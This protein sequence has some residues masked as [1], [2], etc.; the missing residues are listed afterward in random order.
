[1]Y[2]ITYLLDGKPVK[3]EKEKYLQ[4]AWAKANRWENQ[5]GSYECRIQPPKKR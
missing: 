5:G 1:M 4:K 2:T 3:T